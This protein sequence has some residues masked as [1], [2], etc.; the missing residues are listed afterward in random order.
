[1]KKDTFNELPI[2]IQVKNFNRMV[3][4]RSIRKVCEELK[5]GKT[6][7]RNRFEKEGY[8][9]SR[10]KNQYIKDES[11]GFIKGNEIENKQER[12][13]EKVIKSNIILT[14]EKSIQLE[15]LIDMVDDLK[16]MVRMWKRE[17]EM[18]T[19]TLQI[20]NF[21]G[22]LHVKSIKVYEEVLA[23]FN[24]FVEKHKEFKQQEI[25]NQALWEFLRKYQ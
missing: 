14:E 20:K 1:M 17:S 10:D 18:Q 11:I 2:E 8:I 15:E 3:K 13:E 5:I 16:S 23:S 24:G 7:I 22:Q 21:K 6:T 9:F 19:K 12:V 4:D 25:I